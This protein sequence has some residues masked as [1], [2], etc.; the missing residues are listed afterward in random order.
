[1]RV[2]RSSTSVVILVV[3]A[4]LS[5]C[6]GPGMQG[7]SPEQIQAPVPSPT[8]DVTENLVATGAVKQQLVAAAAAQLHLAASDFSGLE[9]GT[10]YYAYDF[11]TRT[12]W[13]AGS[14]VPSP[15]SQKAQIAVQDNGSYDLFSQPK[16]GQWRVYQV[17]AAGTR[18]TTCPVKVPA[19]ITQRWG[20]PRHACRP[21]GP[22]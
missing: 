20:W 2:P 12:Y 6:S 14:L 17:G 7:P 15:R 21:G 9:P 3:A 5:G 4:C 11:T 16:G 10:T 13:A 19:P 22:R 1:M 8:G 18:G